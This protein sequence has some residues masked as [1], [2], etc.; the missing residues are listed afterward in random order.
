[1]HA[2]QLVTSALHV[3]SYIRVSV[4]IMYSNVYISHCMHIIYL[5]C[6]LKCDACLFVLKHSEETSVNMIFALSNMFLSK[7]ITTS[8]LHSTVS[9]Q[10]T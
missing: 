10:I 9:S 4:L 2:F 7:F 1:M 8:Y 3:G 5:E 6:L